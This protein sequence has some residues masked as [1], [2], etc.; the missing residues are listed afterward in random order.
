[1]SCINILNAWTPMNATVAGVVLIL[2]MLALSACGDDGGK[3]RLKI[4]GIPDQNAASLARKYEA[5]TDYLSEELDI[6]VEYVPTVDYAATVIAFSQGEIQ[7]GWFGG[8]T[9]I[10]AR[11]EVPGSEAIAQRPR[12][13]QFHSVFI[14]STRSDVADLPGLSGL[15]FTFGSELSTSGHLMPR[16]F[17][18]EA[19]VDPDSDFAGL[20]NYSGSHDKTWKLVESGAFQ[21]GVLNEAVWEQAVEQ[22]KVDLTRVRVFNT[23]SPYH[24][25]NWTVRGDID[26]RFGDGFARRVQEALIAIDIQRPDLLELFSTDGFIESTNDNYVAIQEIA[27]S[28]GIIER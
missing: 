26:E 7:M 20:P 24:D 21:A 22:G 15:S 13:E 2:T 28:I 18:L 1:M 25:Y 5:L 17:L 3:S 19:G 10:M 12:D 6:E 4:A 16:H 9:G 8:L 27:E 23:T 11:L 14:A